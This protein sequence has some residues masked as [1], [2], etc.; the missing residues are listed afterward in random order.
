M[1]PI[2]FLCQILNQDLKN[3]ILKHKDIVFLN[4]GN[5]RKTAEFIELITRPFAGIVSSY[6]LY[7][8]LGD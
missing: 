7:R 3:P 1:N 2:N 4:D 8:A 5:F 6:G